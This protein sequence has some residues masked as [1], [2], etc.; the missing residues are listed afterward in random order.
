MSRDPAPEARHRQVG[1]ICLEGHQVAL[2]RSTVCQ[3]FCLSTFQPGKNRA[4]CQE[5]LHDTGHYVEIDLNR[6]CYI[7][8]TLRKAG[9]DNGREKWVCRG[10]EIHRMENTK[11]NNWYFR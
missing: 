8:S 10:R 5:I 3:S 7:D 1:T 11:R 9:A 4:N 6:R 2:S